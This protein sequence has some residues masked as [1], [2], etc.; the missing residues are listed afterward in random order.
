MIRNSYLGF[1]TGAVLF[2]PEFTSTYG[3]FAL[4]P[5]LGADF[6]I[7]SDDKFSLGAEA[8]YLGVVGPAY[9]TTDQFALSGAMK[10]WF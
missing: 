7:D 5:T 8:T 3:R 4:G 10:Y 1:K 9:N 2:D 6:P